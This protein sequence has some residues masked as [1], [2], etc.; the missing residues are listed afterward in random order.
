M[1]AN[2][3]LSIAWLEDDGD[4]GEQMQLFKIEIL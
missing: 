4:G 1:P 2:K 3:L